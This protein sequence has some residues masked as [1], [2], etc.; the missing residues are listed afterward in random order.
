MS[1]VTKDETSGLRTDRY[2]REARRKRYIR[3]AKIGGDMVMYIGSAALMMPVIQRAREK[4]SGLMGACA[5][6]AGIVLSIGLGSIASRMMEKTVDK[7]V[8]FW[9]D[10][11]PKKTAEKQE[12]DDEQEDEEN[13]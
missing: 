6:G 7:V 13:G 10:V 1:N 3:N 8:D 9:D 4:Q 2:S 12:V 11:K 5:T